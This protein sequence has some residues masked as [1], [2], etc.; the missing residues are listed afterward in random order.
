MAVELIIFDC[1]GVLVDSEPIANRMLAKHL[2]GI[3]LPTT[4]EQSLARYRGRSLASC[5][6]LIE[7]QMGKRLP[8][9]FLTELQR[10]TFLSFKKHLRAVV[11]VREVVEQ[12]MLPYCVASSGDHDKMVLTLGITGLLPLFS[13]RIYSASEVSNG[14]PHPDLFLYA[15]E[16]MG[17]AA[18]KCLVIEDAPVGVEAAVRAGMQVLGYAKRTD[19]NLLAECGAIT[20]TEMARMIELLD[21]LRE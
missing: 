17:V 9:C 8:D 1:D 6:E 18:E 12:L 15:A 20:F 4:Y 7:Q 2:T 13:G 14:K 21:G 11:G 10:E 16:R 5:V 3:G 19:E